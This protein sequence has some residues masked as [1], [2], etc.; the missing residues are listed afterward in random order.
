MEPNF[1]QYRAVRTWTP[2]WLPDKW[3]ILD[4]S[5]GCNGYLPGWFYSRESAMQEIERLCAACGINPDGRRVTFSRDG[6]A[7]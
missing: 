2:E 6:E 1:S 5:K 7:Y 3:R 4:T